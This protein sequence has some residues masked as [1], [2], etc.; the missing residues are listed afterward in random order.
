M[1]PKRVNIWYDPEA[2]FLEVMWEDRSGDFVETADGQAHVKVDDDGNVLG[3]QILALSK[4]TAPLDV[5]FEYA[6]H[7][8]PANQ[9]PS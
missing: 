6:V 4:L 5:D 2:D 3:F 8:E 1:D 9:A 7:E